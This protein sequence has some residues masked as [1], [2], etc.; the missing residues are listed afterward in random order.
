M[1]EETTAGRPLVRRAVSPEVS[2]VVP[3]F[4]EETTVRHLVQ[5]LR[6][7]L[8]DE[9]FEIILV[10]DGSTDATGEILVELASD[11]AEVVIVELSR[12][13]GQHPAVVAG[14]SVVRGKYVITLD[15]DLQNPPGGDTA[16]SRTAARRPRCRGLGAR[17]PPGPVGSEGRCR[18]S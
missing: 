15:A 18:R 9:S 6:R 17:E 10:N 1:S 13:F 8:A 11:H 4:N 16:S 3:V 7:A 12:N 2:I 5:E 14:F